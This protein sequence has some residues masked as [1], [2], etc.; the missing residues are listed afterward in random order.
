MT[1]STGPNKDDKYWILNKK[2]LQT[3]TRELKGLLRIMM[4]DKTETSK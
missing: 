2:L 3:T 1:N 4:P